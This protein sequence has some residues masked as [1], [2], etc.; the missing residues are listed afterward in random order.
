MA[1]LKNEPRKSK[2]Q[3]VGVKCKLRGP[4]GWVV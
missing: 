3:E 1:H 4:F 2:K